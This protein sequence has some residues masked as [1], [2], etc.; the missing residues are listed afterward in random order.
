MKKE[1]AGSSEMMVS[2]YRTTE[3]YMQ[4]DFRLYTHPHEYLTSLAFSILF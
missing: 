3:H 4:E 1:A 2:T